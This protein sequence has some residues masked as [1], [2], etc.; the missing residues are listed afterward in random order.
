MNHALQ[1]RP[2]GQNHRRGAKEFAVGADRPGDPSVLNDQ[3][4]RRHGA[5]FEVGLIG[6]DR[7]HRFAIEPTI[8]L[9]PWPA[10]SRTLGAVE[11]AELDSGGVRHPAHE[12]VQRVN[13]PNEMSFTQAA[14]SRIAGHFPDGFDSVGEKQGPG[15]E[16]RRRRRRLAAGVAAP[17]HDHVPGFR[18]RPFHGRYLGGRVAS[19][20]RRQCFT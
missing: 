5:D 6:Q 17:D 7:L 8:D 20:E 2:S 14:D 10:H 18:R 16:P 12:A 3:V 13:L 1:E 11:H 19:V 15:A 4:F 9:S